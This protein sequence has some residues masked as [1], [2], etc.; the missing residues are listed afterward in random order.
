MLKNL[1][2]AIKQLSNLC[3]IAVTVTQLNKWNSDPNIQ[4]GIV[5]AYKSKNSK[6]INKSKTSKLVRDFGKRGLSYKPLTG[7][8]QEE[9]GKGIQLENSFIVWDIDFKYLLSLA[10]RYDQESVIFKEKNGLL[11]LY[12]LS[13]TAVIR[14]SQ[15][16]LPNQP[17]VDKKYR[18]KPRD[19][20]REKEIPVLEPDTRPEV[21]IHTRIRDT[22]IRY[23][24][25][26]AHPIPFSNS[27]VSE[28]DYSRALEIPT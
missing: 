9:G 11:G 22:E 14:T 26:W 3:K 6:T 19:Q 13:G 7:W 2:A 24:F 1:S 5:T 23:F 27:P 21:D 8:F 15:E 16:F 4:F 20:R 12:S 10:K 17:T 25:D 18:G 28:R